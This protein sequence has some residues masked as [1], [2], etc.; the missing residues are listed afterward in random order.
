MASMTTPICDRSVSSGAQAITP[1]VYLWN[2]SASATAARWGLEDLHAL[3]QLVA[4]RD[5]EIVKPVPRAKNL[6]CSAS[7]RTTGANAASARSMATRWTTISTA[8]AFAYWPSGRS[9]SGSPRSSKGLSLHLGRRGGPRPRTRH[10]LPEQRRQRHASGR[11]LGPPVGELGRRYAGGR[12]DGAAIGHQDAPPGEKGA[13][14]P[15]ANSAGGRTSGGS[16]GAE[17]PSPAP[18]LH[19]G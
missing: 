18:M 11:G 4:S 9:G 17:H 15:P 8:S 16:K 19:I 12:S 13:R 10:G 14:A 3:A 5:E 1:E 2:A 7:G 6:M